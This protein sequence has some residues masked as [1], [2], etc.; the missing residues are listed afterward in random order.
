[1]S[2]QAGNA[3]H[4]HVAALVVAYVAAFVQQSED[5]KTLKRVADVSSSSAGSLKRQRI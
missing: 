2:G 3:M 1:M 5:H 4:V